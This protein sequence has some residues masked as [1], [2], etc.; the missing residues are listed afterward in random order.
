MLETL[1]RLNAGGKIGTWEIWSEGS[2]LFYA[3][4]QVENGAKVIHS[5]QVQLNQSGRSIEE[6]LALQKKARIS[7]VLDKGYK[8]DRSEALKGSTNQLGLLRPMLA[9]SISKIKNTSFFGAVLQKK[10]DGHRC[11]IRSHDGML[12]AYSRQGKI[13]STIGHITDELVNLPDG[14]TLDGELYCHGKSLQTLSSWIKRKQDNTAKLR[15]MV[16]D[17][18]TEEPMSYKVRHNRLTQMIDGLENIE[19]LGYVDYKSQEHLMRVFADVR[20]R[21][22]EG[23]IIRMDNRP[24]EVGKRSTSLIKVKEFMDEDFLVIDVIPSKDGWGKCVCETDKC[25]QFTTSAP[26]NI[27]QKTEIL[28]N[29]NDYIG[30]KLTVEFACYT[31]D[32]KPFH[33][34]ALRFL[35]LV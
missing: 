6:Q 10:L 3:S 15:Y 1:Y 2:T 27:A 9:Q 29:K 17:L 13:L 11:L 12:T 21:G 34:A 26:G 16:Y 22:Y 32:G 18:I 7:R 35:E 30:R 14:V 33:A 20:K 4:C 25:V 24:Y 8:R 5:E 31:K 28:K 23:V 19:V